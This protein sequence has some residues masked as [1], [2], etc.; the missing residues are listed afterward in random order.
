LRASA[1]RAYRRGIKPSRAIG[2]LLGA[3]F[4]VCAVMRLPA[5]AAAA[6]AQAKATPPEAKALLDKVVAH[7]KK[8]GRKKAFFEF[9]ARRAPFDR[10]DLY[11]VCIDPGHTVV[12]HGG[13]PTY[14]GSSGLFL[15][16]KGNNVGLAILDA[17]AKGNG[18]LRYTIRNLENYKI[19]QKVGYFRT[20]G[21][22]VC[23]VVAPG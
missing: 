12:A 6:A 4:V 2:V 22:D 18:V 13:F 10:L 16:M 20:I 1:A 23:G 7:V 15:D 9:T 8:V 11:V 19:D 5:G 21:S 3:M 14:V 17:P